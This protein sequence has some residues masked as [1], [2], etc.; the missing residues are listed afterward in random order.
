[1]VG[2]EFTLI[3]GAKEWYDPIKPETDFS[4]TD[5]HYILDLAYLYK[6]PKDTVES[7]RFYDLCV[8]CGSEVKENS[9]T[10]FDCTRYKKK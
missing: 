2:I 4:E 6:I 10:E 5:E 8:I 9:C 1:M 7:Y 3:G